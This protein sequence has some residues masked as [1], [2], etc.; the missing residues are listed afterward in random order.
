MQQ[1][2]IGKYI[3]SVSV[4]EYLQWESLHN[5]TFKSTKIEYCWVIHHD[6]ICIKKI[7]NRNFA[8]VRQILETKITIIFLLLLYNILLPINHYVGNSTT[9][10]HSGSMSVNRELTET[11]HQNISSHYKGHCFSFLDISTPHEYVDNVTK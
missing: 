10:C 1:M 7:W 11:F 8:V 9:I 2:F 3:S 4:E 5:K 6:S